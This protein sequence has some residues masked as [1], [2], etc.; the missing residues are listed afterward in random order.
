MNSQDLYLRVATVR[1]GRTMCHDYVLNGE[2][3]KTDE[4]AERSKQKIINDLKQ[5]LPP[6]ERI[7]G[8]E[9]VPPQTFTPLIRDNDKVMRKLVKENLGYDIS[10]IRHL[11]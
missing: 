9:F 5:S 8:A 11:D 10:Y 6:N 3:N 1:N 4:D 7:I 2:V